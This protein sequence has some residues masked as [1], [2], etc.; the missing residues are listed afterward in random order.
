MKD[1][2]RKITVD[3]PQDVDLAILE[4]QVSAIKNGKKKPSVS[5]IVAN[6]LRKFLQSE[7]K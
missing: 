6:A 7:N 4:M 1:K 5:E 3:L 2:A